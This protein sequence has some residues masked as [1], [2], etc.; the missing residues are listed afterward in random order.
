MMIYG[1]KDHIKVRNYMNIDSESQVSRGSSKYLGSSLLTQNLIKNKIPKYAQMQMSMNQ[2]AMS[3]KLKQVYQKQALKEVILDQ[4]KQIDYLE[5]KKK[6][7]RNEL[8]ARE[9]LILSLQ[10]E[11]QD[12]LK[13]K[14][15]L[16]DR[17]YGIEMKSYQAFTDVGDH[18]TRV[19]DLETQLRQRSEFEHQ[20]ITKLEDVSKKY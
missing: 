6:F 12:L 1:K 19:S 17:M 10:Q 3:G 13:D 8:Q 2:S 9:K 18:A 7:H 14:V 20:I 16:K 11:N 5:D 4:K 15:Q